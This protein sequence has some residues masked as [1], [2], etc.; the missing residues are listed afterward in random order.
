MA[1][2]AAVLTAGVPSFYTYYIQ[3]DDQVALGR[4]LDNARY[5][6]VKPERLE[7]FLKRTSAF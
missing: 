1:R 7:A 6:H 4:D 2:L 5:P 3:N